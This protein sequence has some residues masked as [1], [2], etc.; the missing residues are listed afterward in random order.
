MRKITKLIDVLAPSKLVQ[1]DRSVF[2]KTDKE[3]RELKITKSHCNI[4]MR[5]AD[6]KYTKRGYKWTL[7]AK[8]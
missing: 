6:S 5:H 1:I 7:I 4:A 2:Q 8:L 3:K